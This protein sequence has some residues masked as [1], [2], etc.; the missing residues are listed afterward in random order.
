MSLAIFGT[1]PMLKKSFVVHLEFTPNWA[2]SPFSDN[3]T[4]ETR[5][6]DLLD[7]KVEGPLSLSPSSQQ[8]LKSLEILL[9]WI[10]LFLLPSFPVSLRLRSNV[11]LS[12]VRDI[13]LTVGVG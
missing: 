13:S 7:G 4:K 11:L 6:F 5:A 12:C 10:N 9:A 8:S 2:S 1:Y 3:P